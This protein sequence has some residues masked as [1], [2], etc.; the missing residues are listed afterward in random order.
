M[1]R[2]FPVHAALVEFQVREMCQLKNE[3]AKY[4]IVYLPL[5]I[6]PAF[7]VAAFKGSSNK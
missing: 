7:S 5:I 2:I 1:A 6:S 4:K 3:L